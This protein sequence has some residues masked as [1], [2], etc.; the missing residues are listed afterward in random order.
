MEAAE[1]ALAHAE[2]RRLAAAYAFHTDLHGATKFTF[3]HH[4]LP[5][6][7]AL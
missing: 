3:A 5:H 4:S 6:R 2:I 1:R 7:Y